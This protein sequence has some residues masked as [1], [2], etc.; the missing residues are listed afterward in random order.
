MIVVTNKTS[1]LPVQ[2]L[3]FLRSWA[4]DFSYKKSGNLPI[5]CLNEMVVLTFPGRG[6]PRIEH[7]VAHAIISGHGLHFSPSFALAI[8][9]DF[10][11]GFTMLVMESC[12][13]SL[14]RRPSGFY[15][16][17]LVS[18]YSALAGYEHSFKVCCGMLYCS[19]FSCV[20]RDLCVAGPAVSFL[21]SSA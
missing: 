19:L 14:I 4:P 11:H 16:T 18:V 1:I 9:S 3:I 5:Y 8:G 2:L 20:H 13:C 7:V 6:G 17:S 21:L 12:S 15:T 10:W